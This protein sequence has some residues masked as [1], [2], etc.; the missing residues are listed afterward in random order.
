MS[1]VGTTHYFVTLTDSKKGSLTNRHEAAKEHFKNDLKCELALALPATAAAG[2]IISPNTARN[3]AKTVGTG[4][5]KF[6]RYIAKNLKNTKILSNLKNNKLLMKIV[7]NPTKLGVLGFAA[8][9]VLYLNKVA[10]K[11][12]YNRGKID[13]KYED[14]AKIESQTKNVVLQATKDLDPETVTFVK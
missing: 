9:T 1:I 12:S 13:Q 6:G 14:A 10:S 2:A 5:C 11:Y 4:I 3:I 7:K 8:A